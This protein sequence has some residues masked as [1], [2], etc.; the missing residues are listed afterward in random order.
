VFEC[1]KEQYQDMQ[2]VGVANDSSAKYMHA[3]TSV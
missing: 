2:Q 3:F 1:E